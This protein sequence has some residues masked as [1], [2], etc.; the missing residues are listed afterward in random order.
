MCRS[1]Y[2]R[3]DVTTE[4]KLAPPVV[5]VLVADT[6]GQW[7]GRV[8]DDLIEQDYEN[9]QVLVINRGPVS[10]AD[11][12]LEKIPSALVSH[13]PEASSFGE[14]ANQVRD[15]VEGAAFYL[16]IRDDTALGPDAISCLVEEA[17][18]SNAGVVG[19]KI[20]D[21]N[22]PS[23]ILSMGSV[24]DA[25]GVSTP[26]VEPGELDQQQHDRVREVFVVS[27]HALLVRSDLF[28]TIGG[29]D[30]RISSFEE[31]LDLCWRAQIAGGRILVVPA[32][33]VHSLDRASTEID[34]NHRRLRLRYR[35]HIVAKC[36]GWVYLVPILLA[37]MVLSVLEMTYS[38]LVLRFHHARDVVWAWGWNLLQVRNVLKSRRQIARVRETRDRE[39]R[40][41][42][43]AGSSRLRGFL[44]GR[45]G[46][47]IALQSIRGRAGRHVIGSFSPGPRRTLLLACGCLAAILAFGSRHLLTQGVPAY[48]Q[49]AIFPDPTLL[50]SGYWSGWRE[51]G[52]GVTGIGPA[53]LGLLGAAG[54]LT[55]GATAFL[56]E[57]LILGLL[58]VGLLGMWRLLKPIDSL[59]GRI[60][61]MLLY[62]ALPLPYNALAN[63]RWGT[64]LLVA[65]VP[66]AVRR[67]AEAF[68]APIYDQ[69]NQGVLGQT[70]AFGLLI[71][72][73]AA[74]EPLILVLVVAIFVAV[75]IA[76]I[77]SISARDSCRGVAVV[78]M[79]LAVGSLM[80][81]PWV[82]VLGDRDAVLGHLLVRSPAQDFD[83]LA[84]LLRFA[85]DLYGAAWTSWCPLF[86]ALVPLLVGRGERFRLALTA[87]CVA[88]V[89]F[90]LAW[91]S[92][93]GWLTDLTG[94]DVLVSD[95]SLVLAA[96]GVCWCAAVGPSA[97]RLDSS[98]TVSAVRRGAVLVG[99]GSL[100]VTTSV[101]LIESADGRWGSPTNDLRV[102]LSLLDD[103]DIGP[104]YRVLWLGAPEV[105][106]LTGW[107]VGEDGLYAGTSV[108]GH[109]DIRH[110][111]AGATTDAQ[112]QLLNA[113]EIGLSGNT[114]R[115]GRLLAPFGIRYVAVVE[116]ST[117]SF[118]TGIDRSVGPRVRQALGSQLDL[119]PLAADPSVSVLLNESWMSS[120]AQFADPVR[121]AGL[122]EPGELVVT[123]L[124]LGIPVLT[125]RRTGREQ[126]GFVGV[127]EVLVAEAFDGNW[128]L[129]VD[130]RVIMPA[131]SFG[132]AMRFNSPVEGPAVLWHIRPDQVADRAVVQIVL[133]AVIARFAAVDRR[134][135][136]EVG[137]RT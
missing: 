81:F 71:G 98:R 27:D 5:A 24:V 89:G 52:V 103:R 137:P 18:E 12:V 106:P 43:V 35:H 28:T 56:R 33:M 129:L 73:V 32:A 1:E 108:R 58:P 42:Q 23:L 36:Y 20:L 104:S 131:P 63:G 25:F 48:G 3:T 60:V 87:G 121:L 91:S 110:Q 111:W 4:S 92:D 8:L 99:A 39:I 53:A 105:L 85:P 61:G 128:R 47:D 26:I 113:V 123:D 76:S 62:A 6:P 107:P 9:Y 86:V 100:I 78:A 90:S 16:F 59:W 51:I 22:D 49:F 96:V 54:W 17:L 115:M 66:F 101:L 74:F 21:W 93:K 116:R 70:T 72:V 94:Q 45:I 46:G 41:R 69:R 44:Q 10:T 50:L 15:L 29:F 67:V 120:R 13:A 7:F 130:D 88:L 83:G 102:S 112:A 133:W 95:G 65:A 55:F 75:F 19:P 77:G 57:V 117:P 118:S 80:H 68:R 109:P 37:A 34:E 126:R 84:D 114:T 30:P 122:D 127:G 40:R 132:W 31:S 134:R 135:M 124:T 64:L 2:S 119:R 97:L 125:D 136:S 79:S 82:A 11:L 38:L 14:A